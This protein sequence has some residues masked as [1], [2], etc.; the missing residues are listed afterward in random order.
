MVYKHLNCICLFQP[1]TAAPV[2]VNSIPPSAVTQSQQQRQVLPSTT[3]TVRTQPAVS[4]NSQPSRGLN[5]L[6][7]PSPM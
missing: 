7:F 2:A 6:N 1:R 3:T 5:Q 4:S